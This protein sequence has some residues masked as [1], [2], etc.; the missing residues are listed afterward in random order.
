MNPDIGF[1]EEIAREAGEVL[2]THWGR[3]DA[4]EKK[5]ARD[6]VTAADRESE[7]HVVARI[8]ERFKDDAI[9]AEEEH[10]T[11]SAAPRLWIVDPLDGTTNF[12]HRI[13]HV[14]V[15]IAW[16][17]E[18]QV[19][20]G[21][22]H[23]PVLDACY[24]AL[25][26]GGARL[27][28]RPINASDTSQLSEALLATGFHYRREFQPDSNLQ[29]FVDFGTQVRGLRRLGSAACDLCYVAEGRFDGFWELWLAPWD[30]AAGGLIAA[31]AGCKVTG[32]EGG[33]DWLFGR[34][35][36]AA[37]PTL[38]PVIREVLA[39][40]DP[41]RLPGPRWDGPGE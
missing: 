16:C 11:E 12:V 23:N 39:S 28:G 18:G 15:S 20:V 2:L 37:N 25:R 26:G 27:N 19:T 30:V 10:S 1:V 22:V 24:T 21:C 8:R 13:P 38:A 17:E 32:F 3:L 14:A 7:A 41:D 35:I 5:G 36:V 34:R 31:E 40:A 6:L 29:H 4:V 33:D 9:L